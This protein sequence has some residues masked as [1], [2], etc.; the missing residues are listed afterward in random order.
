MFSE[1]ENENSLRVIELKTIFQMIDGGI[2]RQETIRRKIGN[3]SLSSHL[4]NKDTQIHS[5]KFELFHNSTEKY[6]I[7]LKRKGSLVMSPEPSTLS[8]IEIINLL[9]PEKN[10]NW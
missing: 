7:E 2:F 9:I 8:L 1:K 6:I 5:V 10:N 4:S 3:M